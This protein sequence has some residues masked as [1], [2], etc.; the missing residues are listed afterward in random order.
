MSLFI[1]IRG[2]LISLAICLYVV[3]LGLDLGIH[4]PIKVSMDAASS[5]A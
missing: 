4:L 5:A 2:Y 1:V 3:I